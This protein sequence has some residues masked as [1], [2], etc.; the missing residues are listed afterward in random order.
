[1][2]TAFALLGLIWGTLPAAAADEEIAAFYKG[3]QI[4]MMVGSGVGSGYDINARTVARYMGTHIPG[5]PTFVVQNQP[6]AGSLIMVNTLA[7]A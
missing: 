2:R 5:N 1:M 7:N 3:K 4:H 6:G